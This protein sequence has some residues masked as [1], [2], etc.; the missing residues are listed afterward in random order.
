MLGSKRLAVLL[1]AA[2]GWAYGQPALT[3]IQDILYRAD[4]TR[5]S[6]TMFIHYNSFLSGGA[7]NIATAN[8]TIPIVNGVLKVQLVPTTTASA[9]AQY[10][11]T[12]ANRGV[13][14]FTEV[15]AVPPSALPLRVR[16]VR[17]SSGTVIGPAP[18][19]GSPV[20][21]SDVTG[22][23]NALA[24]RPTQGVGFSI[25]RTA[26]INQAGQIDAAT[27]NL[28]DC[29]HVDGS[30]NTCGGGA[31]GGILPLFADAETPSGAV[32]GSNTTFTFF[33]APS[34]IDSLILFRNGVLQKHGTDFAIAGNVVTFFAGSIPQTGDQV[35]GSY[36]YGNPSNPLGTLTAAQVI[37]SSAGIGTSATTSTSL[38]TCT[39]PAGLL[40][41]GDRIEVQFHFRHTGTATAFTGELR[42]GATSIL[43]RTSVAGELA[44]TGRLAFGILTGAQS[45][46]AQSWGNSFALANSVG[47]AAENSALNLTVS[48]RGLMAAT[49]SDI[50][51]LSNFTVVRYPAQT[52]P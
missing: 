52:N 45:W 37:C 35:V 49:T 18:I 25:G 48:F 11:I 5:F 44:F 8:L 16:D 27:G 1:V 36:R 40:T 42:W 9:G 20:Q 43:L 15:W 26:I 30:A 51:T 39:I 4:G 28:G 23:T 3:T 24:I 19:T 14:Q 50:L 7:S 17:L 34:P 21:I 47:S 2:T 29:M 22:L 32:N 31:T 38:G 46:D 41:T 12:Y 10:A 33:F 6:G 13:N